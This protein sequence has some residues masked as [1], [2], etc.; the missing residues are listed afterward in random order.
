MNGWDHTLYIVT[1]TGTT[2][3]LICFFIHW[4]IKLFEDSSKSV[5]FKIKFQ[6]WGK[7][8][9]PSFACRRC[10]RA[11]WFFFLKVKIFNNFAGE[12]VFTFCRG[13]SAVRGQVDF[14]A[15]SFEA[16][17]VASAAYYLLSNRAGKCDFAS[18]PNLVRWV[19]GLKFFN[20]SYCSRTMSK[21]F[22]WYFPEFL[23]ITFLQS[24]GFLFSR[25]P[26]SP[27]DYY[28]L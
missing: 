15:K 5:G 23:T 10:G 7:F 20:V 26:F 27:N 6:K 24:F 21:V 14:G 13:L 17:N 9:T 3:A 22:F 25:V 12:N 11:T 16:P 2:A 4:N 8:P 28:L 19:D 18:K 1:T